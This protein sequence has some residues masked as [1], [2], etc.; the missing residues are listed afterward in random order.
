MR[1][2]HKSIKVSGW[3]RLALGIHI[4][5]SGVLQHS[6]LSSCVLFPNVCGPPT[7]HTRVSLWGQAWRWHRHTTWTWSGRGCGTSSFQK[8]IESVGC[9]REGSK[10]MISDAGFGSGI[11]DPTCRSGSASSVVSG[12]TFAHKCTDSV[13]N[14][15]RV[16]RKH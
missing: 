2:C 13:L 5:V 12:G 8:L 10:I 14:N 1:I 4:P 3:L 16:Q 9:S 7:W 6:E 15:N 11:T